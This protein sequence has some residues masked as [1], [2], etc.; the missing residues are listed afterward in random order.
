MERELR[1]RSLVS[2]RRVSSFSGACR[3]QQ[4]HFG[5]DKVGQS[6]EAVELGGVLGQAAVAR[7]AMP[8]EVLD[9]VKGMLHPRPHLRFELLKLLGQIFD[10]GLLPAL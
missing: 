5:D 4:R 8:E 7:L 1:T 9:D 10:S 2:R 6:E 3:A